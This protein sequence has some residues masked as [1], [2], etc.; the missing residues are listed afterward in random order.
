MKNSFNSHPNITEHLTQ[1][2]RLGKTK[3]E[4]EDE[5]DSRMKKRIP[6]ATFKNHQEQHQ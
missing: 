6:L 3:E 2:E 5:E 4:D 1:T